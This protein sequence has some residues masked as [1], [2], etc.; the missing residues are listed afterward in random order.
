[1]RSALS[2]LAVALAVFGTTQPLAAQHYPS[3]TI[4]LVIPLSPGDGA[5]IAGRA[6][7]DE[8]A[9]LLK[10]A[11]VPMNRPGAAMAIG[12]DSVV[13]SK[14]DGYTIL[15]APNAALVSGRILNPDLVTYDP[16]KDLAPLG[17]TSRT[18]V[19][20]TVRGDAPWKNLAEMVEFAKKNPGKVRAATVGTG[21]VG[22]F[23]VEMVNSLTGAAMTPIPFKGGAPAITALLGG[24]VE[25]AALS[26]GAS[27]PHL[28]SGAMRGL[29]VSSKTPTFPE[30]PTLT[31]LGY[32]QNL[33]GIWFAFYAP[34][35]VPAEVTKVL[36]PAIEKVV[37]DPAIAAR[38]APLGVIQ[39]YAPPDKV[40]A[41]IRE[42][43]RVLE[44][45]AKKAGLVK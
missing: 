44:D 11:V 7:A 4:T 24:H 21:S 38:L 42:E 28:K 40:L 27:S 30:I 45:V 32:R 31:E 23:S 29:V 15:I 20:L 25:V 19:I 14:K 34:A 10:V 22:H 5:D 1:M 36:L 12:T 35:G 17:L 8:L 3:G 6:M 33:P 26:V 39:E 2:L 9:K 18:P 43:Y 13:K 37:K 16:L 41:E